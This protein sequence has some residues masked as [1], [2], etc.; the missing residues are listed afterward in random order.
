MRVQNHFVAMSMCVLHTTFLC[1]LAHAAESGQA[2][3]L[4]RRAAVEVLV[5]DRLAGSGCFVSRDGLLVT[6]AHVVGR[7]DRRIEVRTTH[8]GRLVANVVAFDLGHD[9]ALLRV[10]PHDDGHPYV[11][12]AEHA[13]ALRD[14]LWLYGA[15]MFRHDVLLHGRVARPATAYEWLP[16]EKR[17]VGCYF[18]S[19]PS[20]Q[21]TSGG[22]RVNDAG[23]LV[24]I[25]S[26]MMTIKSAPVGISQDTDEVRQRVLA[27]AR[28]LMVHI[29][30][31]L[32]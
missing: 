24:G 29:D 22:A 3:D 30:Q 19:G 27:A 28:E 10:P 32:P 8:A 5:E 2:F 9:L 21:G 16:D 4:V 12:V 18:V 25:Q 11:P 17:Y 23:E 6:A 20:P 14:R 1:G 15:P 26:G 7:P 13:P 31:N